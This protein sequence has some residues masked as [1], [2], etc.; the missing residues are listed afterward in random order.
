MKGS[1]AE[2]NVL[3]KKSLRR[4]RG[5]HAFLSAMLLLACA[6]SARADA[7]TNP[8]LGDWFINSNWNT[9]VPVAGEF[10]YIE[11]GGSALINGHGAQCG[12]LYLGTFTVSGGNGTLLV[13]ALGTTDYNLTSGSIYMGKVYDKAAPSLITGTLHVSKGAFV[14][15]TDVA[16][17]DQYSIV[18]GDSRDG[19]SAANGMVTVTGTGSFLNGYP[20]PLAIGLGNATGTLV[21]DDAG[22]FLSV[23]ANI[24]HGSVTAKN[25]GVFACTDAGLF[26]GFGGATNSSIDI[27]TGGHVQAPSM[28]LYNGLVRVDNGSTTVT[29]LRIQDAGASETAT[30]SNGQLVVGDHA[31]GRMDIA[32]EGLLNTYRGFIG[33]NTDGVGLAMVLGR[34]KASGSIWVGNAGNGTLNVLNGGTL[35]SA[36]NGYLGF[37]NTAVGYAAV[38]GANSAWTTAG[39]LFIGGTGVAPG[40][41]GQLLIRNGGRV[42]AASV[43]L[44]NTGILSLGANATL[45]GPFTAMGGTLDTINNI[46]FSN[47]FTLG[48]G[49]LIV[50]TNGFNSTFSGALSGTGGFNKAGTSGSGPGTLTLT[51]N[52]TYSG[53]TTVSIGK[54]VV[55]GNISSPVT[56]NNGGILSG[57]GAVGGII[58]AS[59]GIV[60]PGNSPGVLTVNG[61]YTQQSGGILNIEIGGPAPGSGYDRIALSGKATIAGTLNLSLV[62]GYKPTVG[63]TFAIITSISESGNFSTINSTGFTVRS[64]ASANGIVLTVTSVVPGVPVIT[65]STNAS[66]TQ[67]QPFSYQIT[68]T[69]SPTSFGA[70]AL[71][72][73][74][75]VNSTNGVISGTPTVVGSFG[76]TISATNSTATG[77]ATLTI[78]ISAPPPTPG[79]V[80]NVSTRLSVGTGDDALFEGFIIQGP[81]GSS[82]KIIVRAL[83]PFLANFNITDFLPNPTLD[84]FEGSTRVAMNNDWRTT[85]IGGLVTADQSQEIAT[86]GLAPSDELESAI[87]AN[88]APGSYTA[89]VRGLGNTVGQGLVDAYDLSASSQAKV[90]NFSTRGLV[91]PGDKLLTAGFIIQN[92][93]VRAVIRA[94]GPSLAG[95]P[96]N[97]TNALPDTTLQLR[98][99]NGNLVQEN[100]DWE[101]DQR[102]ELLDIGFQPGNPKEAAL[103]RTIPPGQYTAQVRGK[104][105][106]TG[107]GVVEIYF[108]Q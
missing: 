29:G 10:T 58:V 69:E 9:G 4:Y 99:Q 25:K 67:D 19:G 83:G 72:P 17:A 106:A 62:N 20:R 103:I 65:S 34:W 87:I 24:S 86:S 36:G 79:L 73:G 37:E 44:Y 21:C 8:G 47:S 71:P 97:I 13:A 15:T 12:N 16:P 89:V 108:I 30:A 84:I 57:N 63:Q 66:G 42:S 14:R 68:A 88:L 5:A 52:S 64:D 101:T 100:D 70:T 1:L 85:Q 54:L 107:V 32:A 2:R 95:P 60:A 91:Q 104:P 82:K 40:G 31:A 45:V 27:F 6:Q 56:V 43:T 23:G 76:V 39:G 75:S 59:G 96:Y 92:G 78:T 94:I 22:T 11:N 26:L 77:S 55:T 61:N 33:S 81:A 102:Q 7:W 18:I 51:G 105:E 38:D 90:V 93:P 28:Q 80:G 50:R 74:L 48:T 35:T 98:D 46:T 3:M 53:P 41:S 49:G